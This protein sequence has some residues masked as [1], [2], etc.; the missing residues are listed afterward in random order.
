MLGNYLKVLEQAA[1]TNGA[2]R[3]ENLLHGSTVRDRL[4]TV[5][6]LEFFSSELD[7]SRFLHKM[8]KLY[9]ASIMRTNKEVFG[10]RVR[11]YHMQYVLPQGVVVVSCHSKKNCT[12]ACDKRFSDDSNF[13]SVP[14]S[15]PRPSL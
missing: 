5:H 12:K 6:I 14:P 8:A 2:E 10:K 11:K 3:V 9:H 13:V 1:I 15:Q 4:P 7:F